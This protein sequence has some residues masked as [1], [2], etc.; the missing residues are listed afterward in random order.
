MR[1]VR[2]RLPLPPRS[3]SYGGHGPLSAFS[4]TTWQLVIKPADHHHVPDGV[5]DSIHAEYAIR[6]RMQCQSWT[7]FI[8]AIGNARTT[9][10]WISRSCKNRNSTRSAGTY[11]QMAQKAREARSGRKNHTAGESR[12]TN[13]DDGQPRRGHEL[14]C[15]IVTVS[16]AAAPARLAAAALRTCASGS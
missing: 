14:A 4:V 11:T 2:S 15:G 5:P 9:G 1:V 8:R 16:F 12:R 7:K 13:S 3:S 10:Y 6:K